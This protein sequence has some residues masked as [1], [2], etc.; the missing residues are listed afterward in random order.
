MTVSLPSPLKA[1]IATLRVAS[2]GAKGAKSSKSK[3]Q[4]WGWASLCN[5]DP[6]PKERSNGSTGSTVQPAARAARSRDASI[7]APAPAGAIH[8]VKSAEPPAGT[9]AGPSIRTDTP[10]FANMPW[11]GRQP[12]PPRAVPVEVDQTGVGATST[13]RHRTKRGVS[14]RIGAALL[15]SCPERGWGASPWL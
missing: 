14:R 3:A 6:L 2:E 8:A 5:T 11:H 10:P 4:T 12:V 1:I 7:P 15:G 9:S 13:A